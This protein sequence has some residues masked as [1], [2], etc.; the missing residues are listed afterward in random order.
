MIALI[1]AQIL[2]CL[3]RE[4]DLAVAFAA[5]L[6]TRRRRTA[7][8]AEC[9]QQILKPAATIYRPLPG[10]STTS[11]NTTTTTTTTTTFAAI[12]AD[13][14]K[15]P[16]TGY[17]ILSGPA[18]SLRDTLSQNPA[19]LSIAVILS[20]SSPALVLRFI[21]I[22]LLPAIAAVCYVVRRHSTDT[23]R[24]IQIYPLVTLQALADYHS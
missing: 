17:Q 22:R 3:Y 12:N 18:G 24:L 20:P 19:N 5:T 7:F 2:L 8:T 1:E 15:P 9:K 11:T 6:A 23:G 13:T 21:V 4:S 14:F 10:S 16:L